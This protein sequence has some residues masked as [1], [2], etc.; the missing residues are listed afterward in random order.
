MWSSGFVAAKIGLGH[1]DTLTFPGLRYGVVT[2]LTVGV[3]FAMR[4]PWPKT[5]LEVSHIA[6]AGALLLFV[7]ALPIGPLALI[8]EDGFIR[9]TPSFVAALAYMA[10]FLSLVSMVLLT[11]MIRRGAVS[12]VTSMF[13]LVPPMAPFAFCYLA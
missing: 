6:V 2:L 11:V 9:W 5:R 4:A 8:F 3:A 12:R 1:A 7:A 10:V 13:F